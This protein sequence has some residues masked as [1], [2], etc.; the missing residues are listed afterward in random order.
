MSEFEN[1]GGF[2]V[3]VGTGG[4]NGGFISGGSPDKVLNEYARVLGAAGYDVSNTAA[5][6]ASIQQATADGWNFSGTGA[7]PPGF[8]QAPIRN[9]TTLVNNDDGDTQLVPETPDAPDLGIEVLQNILAGVTGVGQDP[10]TI[11]HG[12]GPISGGVNITPGMLGGIDISDY[13]GVSLPGPINTGPLILEDLISGGLEGLLG[14]PSVGS[15][16]SS[17][18]SSVSSGGSTT[19]TAPE[20][21]QEEPE[22][23]LSLGGIAGLSF[24][25][26]LENSSIVGSIFPDILGTDTGA[27]TV[28]LGGA[29]V[30]GADAE[31]SQGQLL[32]SND[33]L[34]NNPGEL[35][36]PAG[37]NQ[38]GITITQNDEPL[39]GV[40]LPGAGNPV[41]FGGLTGPDPVGS[42]ENPGVTPE[43]SEGLLSSGGGGGGGGGGAGNEWEDFYATPDFQ[44]ALANRI[45]I[46]PQDYLAAIF[47]QRK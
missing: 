18:G 11:I 1:P 46:T 25:D 41:D 22:P 4:G 20:P 26:P 17:G 36:A 33:G 40:N 37:T 9:E 2:G 19:P 45:Q 29:V 3:R 35:Q 8:E 12:G 30:P 13:I 42:A 34:V 44:W 15:G 24:P 43:A 16:G 6:Y 23:P 31:L 21:T 7:T 28:N 5:L 10:A 39:P 27:D 32:G 38:Y 14:G 47:N